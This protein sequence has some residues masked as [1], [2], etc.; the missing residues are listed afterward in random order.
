MGLYT[1]YKYNLCTCKAV[2]MC[3]AFR[4]ID[5]SKIY[6]RSFEYSKYLRRLTKRSTVQTLV[7][8]QNWLQPYQ[9]HRYIFLN[10]YIYYQ[11]RFTMRTSFIITSFSTVINSLRNFAETKQKTIAY[12]HQTAIVTCFRN[13]NSHSFMGRS[14]RI[15]LT[16]LRCE[17]IKFNVSCA[18]FPPVT[19]YTCVRR[20]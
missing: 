11:H 6:N 16:S 7:A 18:S 20:T 2:M 15:R 9:H 19:R 10:I 4:S 3:N 8:P 13:S 14:S 12:Q 5:N 1:I 17:S